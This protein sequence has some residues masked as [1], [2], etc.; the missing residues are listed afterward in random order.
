M[1]KR[2]VVIFAAI[3]VIFAAGCATM[4]IGVKPWGEMSVEEKMLFFVQTWNQ[5]HVDT[6]SMAIKGDA[7]SPAQKEIVR[8]KK[9]LLEQT[10]PLIK[11]YVEFVQDGGIPT[12]EM[13]QE[14]LNLI[15]KLVTVGG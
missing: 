8:K 7:L 10:H 2:S 5:Q 11:F 12:P 15:N 4:N 6:M 13:E 14:I 3:A 9:E 1:F